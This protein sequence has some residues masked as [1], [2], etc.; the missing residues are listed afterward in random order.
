MIF[1]CRS[2]F[3][4]FYEPRSERELSNLIR[5]QVVDLAGLTSSFKC[6]ASSFA[7]G[8][9]WSGSCP[10]WASGPHSTRT[11]PTSPASLSRRTEA[12]GSLW[13]WPSRRPSWRSLRR[14]RGRPL[15]QRSEGWSPASLYVRRQG[16]ICFAPIGHLSLWSTIVGWGERSSSAKWAIHGLTK[17]NIATKTQRLWKFKGIAPR[18]TYFL[19]AYYNKEVLSVHL[20]VFTIFCRRHLKKLPVKGLC[21]RCFSVWDL[22]LS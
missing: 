10:P 4:L 6:R 13:T 5:G 14:A 18:D 11:G 19:N 2:T 7:A 3:F 12:S 9:I 17:D 21:G 1:V 16:P 20:I 8:P 15:P 22:L